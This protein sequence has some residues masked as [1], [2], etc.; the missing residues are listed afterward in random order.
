[1]FKKSSVGRNLKRAVCKGLSTRALK[2][3]VDGSALNL[4]CL[5]LANTYISYFTFAA[6]LCII[7]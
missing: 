5:H 4:R 7:R 6:A 2:K 1:M 3:S